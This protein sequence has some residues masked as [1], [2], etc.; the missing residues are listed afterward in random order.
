MATPKNTPSRGGAAQPQGAPRS[1]GQPQAPAVDEEDLDD[2]LGD[3]GEEGT[4]AASPPRPSPPQA[5]GGPRRGALDELLVAAKRKLG[6]PEDADPD[7]ILRAVIGGTVTRHGPPRAAC[8]LPV[9]VDGKRVRLSPGDLIPAGVD[10]ASLPPHAVT[11]A[12]PAPE[13]R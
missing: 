12:L 13:D 7:E 3:D 11:T 10:V 5:P 4:P 1:A 2:V 8:R 6:L 9:M